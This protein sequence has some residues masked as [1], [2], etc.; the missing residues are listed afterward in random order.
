MNPIPSWPELRFTAKPM[1]IPTR[2][3]WI[4]QGQEALRRNDNLVD[5]RSDGVFGQAPAGRARH[6]PLATQARRDDRIVVL[7][8]RCPSGWPEERF[9][10]VDLDDQ[11]AIRGAIRSLAP[12]QV[13]HT[14]GRTPPATDDDLYRGNFWATIRLLNALRSLNRPVRVT[15]TGS[16]AELGAVPGAGLPVAE[17]HPCNP[18]EAYGRS[19][20]MATVAGLAEHPPLEVNVARDLN[21]IGPGLPPTQAFGEFFRSS[22]PPGP[23]RFSWSWAISTSGAISSTSRDV[24]RA[25][26]AVALRAD[27][28]WSTTSAP[29]GRLPCATGWRCWFERR[30]SGQALHR[31]QPRPPQ[32]PPGFAPDI[33]RISDHTG[34]TPTFKFEQSIHDLWNELRSG[35][36]QS[37]S[38][39]LP[40]LPLTA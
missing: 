22:F 21:P 24:A 15:L 17:S 35:R 18:I 13:I 31:P 33:S 25:L 26:V 10:R 37:R 1:Q 19:K 32:G 29:A 2:E 20:W 3:L 12:D 5:H 30:A 38:A 36:D 34:W 27:R 39:D 7:G 23:T 4:Y 11:E 6:A 14:A 28:G 9:L 40:R 16:A 8:R